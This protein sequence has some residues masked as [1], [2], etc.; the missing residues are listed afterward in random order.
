MTV[1][2]VC[3]RVRL[4]LLV[5]QIASEMRVTDMT[6]T[7]VTEAIGPDEIAEHEDAAS[8]S[9][10][11]T[12]EP[13]TDDIDSGDEEASQT[14][15]KPKRQKASSDAP[16]SAAKAAAKSSGKSSA[17]SSG[18]A[19]ATTDDISTESAMGPSSAGSSSDEM[20]EGELVWYNERKG[21]GFVRIGEDEVFLHRS[22]LDRF[23]LVR[24]LTGDIVA[25]LLSTNE[26]G[27]VIK[28]LLSVKRPLSPGPPAAHEPEEGELRAV[29]KF[30]ND[31][32]G[33]G[34]V[35]ADNLEDDVFVHSRVLNDCGF[36]SLI[37]G[38]KLLVKVDDS[39]HGLQV[40]SVRLLAD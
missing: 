39:G 27:Q 16:K 23:G 25:V 8:A 1:V 29:V 33:Y 22:T 7:N 10:S 5:T 19:T 35:T 11:D 37:Q 28:D 15:A 2:P 26:H 18:K 9:I 21:Y 31:L 12:N 24:L 20:C 4:P 14:A 40:N 13:E 34:F 3:V 32:R 6:D 38:Q 30:F 17:K 36:S